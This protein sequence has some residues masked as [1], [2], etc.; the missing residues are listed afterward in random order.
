MTKCQPKG[1]IRRATLYIMPSSTLAYKKGASEPF[2]Q[3]AKEHIA[4]WIKGTNCF[5]NRMAIRSTT[6]MPATK[7][8]QG[9]LPCLILAE[10]EAGETVEIASAAMCSFT[11]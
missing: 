3:R 5:D 8:P 6:E 4:L 7:I 9:A 1:T 10:T 11:K 2:L